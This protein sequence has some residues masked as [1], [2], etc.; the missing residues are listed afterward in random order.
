MTVVLPL[1]NPDTTSPTLEEPRPAPPLTASISVLGTGPG[2]LAITVDE[3]ASDLLELEIP[4]DFGVY[5][6]LGELARRDDELGDEIYGVVA[7]AA[8]LGRWGLLIPELAI[9]LTGIARL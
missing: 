9:E 1:A 8:E 3:A 2:D 4:S 6:D 5:K 7:V